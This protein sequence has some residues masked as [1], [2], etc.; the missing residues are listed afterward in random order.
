MNGKIVQ[1]KEMIN[2]TAEL[3]AQFDKFYTDGRAL[4]YI[5][6]YWSDFKTER[7]IKWLN[8]PSSGRVLKDCFIIN[9]DAMADFMEFMQDCGNDAD[10]C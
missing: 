2:K 8:E 9:D 4:Q 10:K 7:S 5:G 3:K 6:A 1:N